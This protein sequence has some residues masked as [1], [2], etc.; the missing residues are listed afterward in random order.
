MNSPKWNAQEAL[1]NLTGIEPNAIEVG[2]RRRQIEN[3]LII[4]LQEIIEL[5]KRL[6]EKPSDLRRDA[7]GNPL[8]FVMEDDS[9]QVSGMI[10]GVKMEGDMFAPTL[11]KTDE[12]YQIM[13]DALR[14]I[15][16]L[17][18]GRTASDRT[19]IACDA[20]EQMQL[21]NEDEN[22]GDD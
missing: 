14:E 6:D 1:D 9:L 11:S 13:F 10:P 2:A 16:T 22:D 7:D 8:G 17:S 12:N 5:Q 4:A 21:Y 3:A 18:S 15:A 19:Q 20:L